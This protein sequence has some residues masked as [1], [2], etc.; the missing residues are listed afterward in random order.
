[1]VKVRSRSGSKYQSE[2]E[3][4]QRRQALQEAKLTGYE[5]KEHER[6]EYSRWRHNAAQGLQMGGRLL[7]LGFEL[8]AIE[9][10][11]KAILED[12][13]LN[14]TV[15][16]YEEAEMERDYGNRVGIIQQQ[17]DSE[18]SEIQASLAASG[19]MLDSGTAQ[20]ARSTLKRIRRDDLNE[21]RSRVVAGRFGF[22]VRRANLDAAET[23]AREEADDASDA[24]IW[25]TIIS[26]GTS[27]FTFGTM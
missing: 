24:A 3:E 11:K 22:D 2:M 9:A 15:L 14:R 19:V 27:A 8:D 20:Q 18:H 26:V 13:G 1:M 4:Y 23:R 6:K 21:L 25:G 12:I 7:S 16:A 10:Q 17:L 5:I